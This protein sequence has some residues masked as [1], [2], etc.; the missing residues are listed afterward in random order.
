ML[1]LPVVI[2]S[3]LQSTQLCNYNIIIMIKLCLS[4][5]VLLLVG[6]AIAEEPKQFQLPEFF[7]GEWEVESAVI[8]SDRHESRHGAFNITQGAFDSV[9]RGVIDYN[10][11]SDDHASELIVDTENQ[12]IK[13]QEKKSDDE[14]EDFDGEAAVEEEFTYNFVTQTLYISQG[15]FTA[16]K[17]TRGGTYEFLVTSPTTFVL[18]FVYDNTSK[19]DFEVKRIVGKKKVV[20]A[21]ASFLARYGPTILIAVVFMGSRMLQ[22]KA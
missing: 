20:A 22:N 14:S 2:C 6:L 17:N 13:F 9:L 11:G 21:E 12:K 15:R 18:S 1:C 3:H 19:D 7:L 16:E 5:C 8:T 4:V 10:D